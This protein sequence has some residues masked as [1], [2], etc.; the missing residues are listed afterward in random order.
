MKK[1]LVFGLLSLLILTGVSARDEDIWNR[2][3]AKFSGLLSLIQENYYREVDEGKLINSSIRGML[4]T[5]DP[6]SYFLDP[7]SLSRMREEYTGKYYGLGIQ[8]QKHGESLV[9]IAPIEGSP[10]SRLGIQPGDIISTIEGESTKPLTSFDALQRLRGPKG[11]KVT[12][13]IVREGLDEPLEMT[14]EREEIPLHSVPYAFMI[15]DTTGYIF[16]RNFAETTTEEFKDKMALL[17]GQGMRELVL[18]LRWNTGGPFFQSIEL[19]DLFLPKGN[20]IVSIKGR[21]RIYNRE[22]RAQRNDQFE[23]IPLVIL[24]NR[25]SASASEIVSGAV[26]DNDRGYVVGEDSWGKGLVQTVFPLSDDFAVALTTAKYFTP[27][28]R[29]IQR[30]FEHIE[31]Y[32]LYKRA[33]DE[34]R[35]VKYTA[36]GRKVLGQGGIAPD[37]KVT[38][39]LHGFTIELM[40]RGAFF[41]Y[42]R[43]FAARE[44]ALAGSFV[45]PN[46]ERD[47][48]VA[49]KIPLAR[50]LSIGTP[51]L[52]D[53]K[54]YL[55]T[56]RIDFEEQRFKEA[57]AEI[58]RELEREIISSVWGV[59]EG[60][61]AQRKSDAVVLKALEVMPEASKFIADN[62]AR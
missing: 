4:E 6:H 52:E 3:I 56:A 14:I 62:V 48:A 33:P 58:K 15:T 39:S 45:F 29:S 21:N 43:R 30:D 20:V 57:E 49:G 27:S 42:A 11:T 8:I 54:S 5:L 25:G 12:I 31:D 50:D 16:I 17:S 19:S 26:M 55:K 36:K 13:T 59:E 28:G 46:D 2:S 7:D 47:A 1:K 10:A 23:T 24:I 18:D 53:F 9:V 51:L 40:N 34:E 41:G 22:F 35:E 32:I 61:R 60:I 38:A 44:T 37:Y